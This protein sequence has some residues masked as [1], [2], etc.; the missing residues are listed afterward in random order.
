M[1]QTEELLDDG[2]V[3]AIKSHLIPGGGFVNTYQDV[4][5]QRRTAEA[6]KNA[7]QHMEKRVHERTVELS[8]LNHKL[9][10]EIEERAQVEDSRSR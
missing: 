6:L 9:R 7:Y 3:I 4:T 2:R 5:Q 10:N 8:A 1:F